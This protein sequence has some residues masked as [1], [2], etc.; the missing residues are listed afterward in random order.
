MPPQ[1]GDK[2]KFLSTPSVR[3]ATGWC[4]CSGGTSAISIHALREEGDLNVLPEFKADA[5]FLSTPS[6]RRAT[7]PFRLTTMLNSISIH[8]LREEGDETVKKI[9]LE[10]VDFYPRPPRG[11][12]RAGYSRGTFSPRF[13]STPSA[14]RATCLD[15]LLLLPHGISIHALREEGDMEMGGLKANYPAFLST[16]SARRATFSEPFL[17]YGDRISIHA[18]REEGDVPVRVRRGIVAD[19][20]IHALREEGD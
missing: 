3:R 15:L 9:I 5:V 1:Q 14:R 10:L 7:K 8:A 19:I 4:T 18:L 2:K 20:S 12:R 13:L 11:G 17:C 16:P 6:V